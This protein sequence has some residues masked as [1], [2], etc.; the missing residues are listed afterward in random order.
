MTK[1]RAEAVQFMEP[2]WEDYI[3]FMINVPQQNY[4]MIYTYPF[5]VNYPSVISAG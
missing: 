5:Q 2:F 3:A 4:A 1:D